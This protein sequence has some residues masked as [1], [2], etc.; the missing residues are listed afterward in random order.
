MTKKQGVSNLVKVSIIMAEKFNLKWNDFQ[1]NASRSFGVLR[2]EEYLQDVTLVSDDFKQVKAHRLV[3][4]ACSEYFKNLLQSIKQSEPWIC[5][6]GVSSADLRN[7]L[8]YVYE[9]EVKIHQEDLDRFLSVAER[10]KLD[11]L[12]GGKENQEE[13]TEETDFNYEP[14]VETTNC[15]PKDYSRREKMIRKPLV[16]NTTAVVSSDSVNNDLHQLA[17]ENMLINEDGT[18]SCK[19]CGK[20][21][22]GSQ[23][24]TIM[25]QHMQTHVEG[26][27]VECPVCQKTFRS[28]NSLRNHK[29][30]YHKTQF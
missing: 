4:S 23:Q 11:G 22:S 14:Q 17:D 26:A 9:G 25:R 13:P 27:S 6:E 2:N 15:T 28:V 16:K 24:K 5:L 8:D 20:V 19:I 21:A 29:S 30:V 18:L 7:V 10:L 1:S 12:I 3:L